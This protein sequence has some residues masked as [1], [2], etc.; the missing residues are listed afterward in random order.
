[1]DWGEEKKKKEK[2]G[3]KGELG[4]HFTPLA[5]VM[6]L[7]LIRRKERREKKEKKTRWRNDREGGR[8][9]SG[10]AAELCAN[11]AATRSPLRGERGGGEE[12][13]EEKEGMTSHA[14]TRNPYSFTYGNG[15]GKARGQS[16]KG[17]KK[18]KK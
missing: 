4:N 11:P 13:K 8:M 15:L 5:N 9:K 6:F 1:M 17:G 18:K 12:K 3:G 16:L 10:R 14:A 7:L 2:G